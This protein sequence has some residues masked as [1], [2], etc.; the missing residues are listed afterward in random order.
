[1]MDWNTG[2]WAL[3]ENERFLFFLLPFFFSQLLRKHCKERLCKQY[4]WPRC[5]SYS[6]HIPLSWCFAFSQKT[7]YY[8]GLTSAWCFPE[9]RVP[10]WAMVVFLRKTLQIIWNPP[11][12]MLLVQNLLLRG[13]WTLEP[14]VPVISEHCFSISVLES[15]LLMYL[16]TNQNIF[17]YF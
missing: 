15:I 12:F 8:Q 3:F 9:S 1:M 5:L 16:L 6:L 13:P 11:P 14:S 4:L 2:L 17:Q 7:C 10:S